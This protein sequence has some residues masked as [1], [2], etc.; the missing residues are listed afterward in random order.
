MLMQGEGEHP[1]KLAL[2][3]VLVLPVVQLA[4]LCVTLQKWPGVVCC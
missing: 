3:G 1:V 4:H 2:K